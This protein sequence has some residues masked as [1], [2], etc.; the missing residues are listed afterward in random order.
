M[1]LE[2]ATIFVQP[3][4]HPFMN[5]AG[6]FVRAVPLRFCRAAALLPR[7]AVVFALL[8][9][10]SVGIAIAQ[11]NTEADPGSA[12]GFENLPATAVL[13]VDIDRI[14][15]QSSA[16]QSIAAAEAALAEAAE[17]E[18]DARRTLLETESDALSEGRGVWPEEEF[19]A[20]E[21]AF[22][23][24]VEELR[25]LRRERARDIQ[26]AAAEAR[27]ELKTALEPILVDLM[28]EWRAAVMLD[29]RVVILRASALDI[30]DEA[31][32]RLDEQTPS[33]EVRI[34]G[35]VDTQE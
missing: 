32:L 16:G 12:L 26:R 10:I 33:I 15:R 28:R 23:R 17:Q 31:I 8:V 30:T 11:E 35:A 14:Y 3:H 13:I 2:M 29:S 20:R 4:P 34:E 27:A 25:R 21:E 7:I 6:A 22:R 9:G 19:R 24:D 5:R 1:P 18:L